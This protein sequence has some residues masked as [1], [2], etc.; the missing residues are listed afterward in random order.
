MVLIQSNILIHNPLLF[1]L[2]N[3]T[4]Q[5]QNTW[6]RVSPLVVR[7]LPHSKTGP[8]RYVGPPPIG[9]HPHQYVQPSQ[10]CQIKQIHVKKSDCPIQSQDFRSKASSQHV[11]KSNPAL[12]RYPRY[13]KILEEGGKF[14]TTT[15][16][17]DIHLSKSILPKAR[18]GTCLHPHT[19]P[20]RYPPTKFLR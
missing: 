10:R 18:L 4:K 13:L 11:L 5:A 8:T 7:G 17:A 2:S 16:F 6:F 9:P 12:S 14:Y 15:T 19:P 1:V 20:D 3:N